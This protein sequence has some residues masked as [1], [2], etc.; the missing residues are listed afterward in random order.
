M[1]T[2]VSLPASRARS[3]VLRVPPELPSQKATR[4]S[5]MPISLRLRSAAR[6]ASRS[7]SKEAAT[8]WTWSPFARA[9]RV[10]AASTPLALPVTRLEPCGSER[11]YSSTRSRSG[12]CRLPTIATLTT[13]PSA[14]ARRRHLPAEREGGLSRFRRSPSAG[15]RRRHLPAERGGGLSRSRRGPSAGGGRRHLPAERGGGLSRFRRR[16][17]QVLVVA[18]EHA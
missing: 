11:T 5:A 10:A 7:S 18:L 8:T 3:I 12:K 2:W 15:A 17:P 1:K 9:T 13:S 14:G 16:L 6:P 4:T